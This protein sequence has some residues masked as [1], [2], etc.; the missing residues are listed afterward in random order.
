M[1]HLYE[2]MPEFESQRDVLPNLEILINKKHR[3]TFY[4]RVRRK[5]RPNLVRFT[6]TDRMIQLDKSIWKLDQIRRMLQQ[7]DTR[8]S[9]RNP[10]VKGVVMGLA[11][12]VNPKPKHIDRNMELVMMQALILKDML[13]M[14]Y[15]K[16]E[17]DL[18]MI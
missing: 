4:F 15:K 6:E 11:G 16:S 7:E 13:N 10:I 3:I 14:R 18:D 8:Q 17:N 12:C 1:N 9:K 5:T 2:L